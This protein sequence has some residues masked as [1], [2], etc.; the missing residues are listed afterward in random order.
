M[1]APTVVIVSG[2]PG[3]GKT[4]LARQ[5]A[6]RL[7]LPWYSRDAIKESLFDTLGWLDRQRS[8]ELGAASVAVLFSL[9]SDTLGT[10]TSCLTESNFRRTHSS[11][12]FQQLLSATGA[13]PLQ[14]QCSTDGD[15][16][17][18]RFTARSSSAERHPGHCDDQNIDEFRGELL[19]GRYEP[20]DLPGP[21]LTVDTTRFDDVDVDA[22]AAQVSALLHPDVP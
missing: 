8:K 18:S 15:T 5:L 3:T 1:P 22:L 6:A 20:L 9:L 7:T 11:P 4:Y 19:L 2:P 21:V 16:L 10:G 13:N 17:L 12:D 14:I